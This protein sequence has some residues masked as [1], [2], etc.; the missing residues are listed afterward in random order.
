MADHQGPL[1]LRNAQTKRDVQLFT[2][3]VENAPEGSPSAYLTIQDPVK[4]ITILQGDRKEL[5]RILS[6]LKSGLK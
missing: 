2:T 1:I 5:M 6:A 3:R 4:G